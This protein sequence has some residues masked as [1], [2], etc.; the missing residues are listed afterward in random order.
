MAWINDRFA[1]YKELAEKQSGKEVPKED[2]G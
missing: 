2:G 1:H